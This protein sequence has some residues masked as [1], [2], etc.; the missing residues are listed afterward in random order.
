M[1]KIQW[2]AGELNMIVRLA[3]WPIPFLK[4]KT[5]AQQPIKFLD[6]SFKK[7]FVLKILGQIPQF[8][9]AV[10]AF[11]DTD[12]MW[13][14]AGTRWEFSAGILHP[15]NKLHIRNECLLILLVTITLHICHDCVR[16]CENM[17]FWHPKLA[18]PGCVLITN[19]ASGVSPPN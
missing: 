1:C 7:C 6:F 4:T 17:H 18:Q 19:V 14:C 5:R 15:I 16:Q 3:G 9:L 8:T 12:S 10:S 2:W 11:C 13:Y